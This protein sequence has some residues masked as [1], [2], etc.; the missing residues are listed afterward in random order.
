MAEGDE[1]AKVGAKV[2]LVG[3]PPLNSLFLFFTFYSM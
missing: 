1:K 3:P 2:V